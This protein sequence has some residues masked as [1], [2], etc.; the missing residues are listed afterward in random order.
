M[1]IGYWL[2]ASIQQCIEDDTL[3]LFYPPV[4]LAQ[5]KSPDRLLFGTDD[6]E[7]FC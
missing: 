3:V 5:K 2:F 4:Y 6:R 1:E 7:M